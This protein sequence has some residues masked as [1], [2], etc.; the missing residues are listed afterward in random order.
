MSAPIPKWRRFTLAATVINVY[1]FASDDLTALT[2]ISVPK[3]AVILDILNDKPGVPAYSGVEIELWKDGMPTGRTFFSQSLNPTSA[4]RG[5]IGPI[6]V[7]PGRIGFRCRPTA[8]TS[9]GPYNFIV[10]LDR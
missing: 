4:G 6:P 10:K 5:S 7:T 3:G 1:A 8:L 9:L 2:E